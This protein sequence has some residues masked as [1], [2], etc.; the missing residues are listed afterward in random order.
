MEKSYLLVPMRVQAM[1]LSDGQSVVGGTADFSRLPWN[2]GKEDIN[3]DTAFISEEIVRTPLENPNLYL[4]PGVHLHWT[5]PGA[6]GSELPKGKGA[7]QFPASPNRWLVVRVEDQNKK[8]EWI[9]E[10][11]YLSK[12]NYAYAFG[13]ATVPIPYDPNRSTQQPYRYMGRAVPLKEWPA[14]KSATSEHWTDYYQSPLTTLGYGDPAFGSFY[15]NSPNVF[16]FHDRSMTGTLPPA[17]S[18]YVFGWYDKDTIDPLYTCLQESHPASQSDIIEILKKTFGWDLAADEKDNYSKLNLLCFGEIKVNGPPEQADAENITLSMGNTGTEALSALLASKIPPD[19][20]SKV[21]DQLEAILMARNIESLQ[22]DVSATFREMRHSKGFCSFKSG[23]LWQV[24][25]KINRASG[26]DN[27][28]PP[29]EVSL[30]AEIAH[31]LNQLNLAQQAFEHAS[32]FNRS[33]K[34]QL[35][36]DW[37]KFMICCFPPIGENKDYPDIDIVR[38]FLLGGPVANCEQWQH[39]VGQYT[40]DD[41]DAQ[42]PFSLVRGNSG[43][44]ASKVVQWGNQIAQHLSKINQDN[45]I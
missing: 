31:S 15:P 30:P 12:N 19:E 28:N 10:S 34:Q 5:L 6:L 40:Y 24:R 14:V 21:E 3:P 44:F 37:Y 43:C 27:G 38:R 7:S 29:D 17:L 16:G 35:F 2:N 32:E 1:S 26:A 23:N 36:C 39:F 22:A 13:S 25:P 9:I 33:L 45:T 41:T 8:S 20:K 11:D 4:Q 18:Y 42:K